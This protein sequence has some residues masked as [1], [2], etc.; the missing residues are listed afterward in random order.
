MCMLLLSQVVVLEPVSRVVDTVH[1]VM[2]DAIVA[3]AISRRTWRGLSG[4]ADTIDGG[5]VVDRPLESHHLGHLGQ[6]RPLHLDVPLR[7]LAVVKPDTGPANRDP[8][9]RPANLVFDVG[10]GYLVSTRR[11][12]STSASHTVVLLAILEAEEVV[13]HVDRLVV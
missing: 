11:L 12:T 1:V 5:H 6:V 13:G 8:R 10:R 7:D 9:S 2:I 3:A 4:H